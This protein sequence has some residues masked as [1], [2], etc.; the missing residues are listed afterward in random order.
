M[1][2]YDFNGTDAE[3]RMQYGGR[4]KAVDALNALGLTDMGEQTMN[5]DEKLE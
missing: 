4:N 5:P 2:R 3:K 1:Q